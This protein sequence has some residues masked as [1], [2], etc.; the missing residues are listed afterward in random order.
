MRSPARSLALGPAQSWGLRSGPRGSGRPACRWAWPPSARSAGTRS[1]GT[2]SLPLLTLRCYLKWRWFGS[3]FFL[4]T[5]P[6]LELSSTRPAVTTKNVCCVTATSEEVGGGRRP[7]MGPE[8][9]WIK[10]KKH[11]H[12]TEN[13]TNTA[14]KKQRLGGG[15]FSLF[16]HLCSG[17]VAMLEGDGSRRM[18]PW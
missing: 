1:A 16:L 9:G 15:C 13:K 7:R 3:L 10:K 6:V 8:S 11:T 4:K 12:K 14:R 5:I 17:S 18:S 2:R